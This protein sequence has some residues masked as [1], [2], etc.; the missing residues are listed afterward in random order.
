MA[1]IQIESTDTTE[2]A[3]SMTLTVNGRT[4]AFVSVDRKIWPGRVNV[5]CR[6]AQHKVWRGL[7]RFFD[8]WTE[9]LDG[10][11]SGD[12]KAAIRT[13]MEWAEEAEAAAA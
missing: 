9:A 8:S 3:H 11:R 7:G 2:Y 10:Y 1:S 6:N 12:M 4:S 13:A 5:C